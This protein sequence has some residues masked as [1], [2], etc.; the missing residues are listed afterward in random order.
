MDDNLKKEEMEDS[1]KGLKK[2]MED[3]IQSMCEVDFP[4]AKMVKNTKE[5]INKIQDKTERNLKRLRKIDIEDED[6][7]EN[8]ILSKKINEYTNVLEQINLILDN[9]DKED[10]E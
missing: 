2:L 4:G 7:I 1:L 9:F 6:N 3:I 8:I 10:K 5:V